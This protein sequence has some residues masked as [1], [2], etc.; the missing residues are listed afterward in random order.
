MGLP[1]CP[2]APGHPNTSGEARVCPAAHGYGCQPRLWK[3][4]DRKPT[5]WLWGRVMPPG[6]QRRRGME[7][8]L[9]SRLEIS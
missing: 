2:H 3:L 4:F 8:D 9:V 6:R 1:A 7:F 5:V